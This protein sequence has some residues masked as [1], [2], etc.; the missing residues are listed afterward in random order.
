MRVT[1]DS[2]IVIA[3]KMTELEKLD[4]DVTSFNVHGLQCAVESTDSQ[5]E[6]RVYYLTN[7][8]QTY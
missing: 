6:G 2:L 4:L 3:K 5:Q 8:I 7:V 1:A